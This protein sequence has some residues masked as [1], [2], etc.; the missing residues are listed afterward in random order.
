[1]ED[2]IPP[3]LDE[4]P[5]PPGEGFAALVPSITLG[6]ALVLL[7]AALI[8]FFIRRFRR[9]PPPPP[10][11]QFLAIAQ[12]ELNLLL[13]QIRSASPPSAY[14]VGTRV[15]STIRTYLG[16][17]L[18]VPLLPRTTQEIDRAASLASLADLPRSYLPLA[19]SCDDLTFGTLSLPPEDLAQLVSQALDA[20][21]PPRPP[22]PP[23]PDPAAVFAGDGNAI[24]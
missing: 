21:T 2:G 24:P 11:P 10:L 23:P 22:E 4:L 20:L 8:V 6:L 12:E 16:A 1:M 9:P 14:E 5:P 15:S 17:Q 13:A 7:L 18:A 3:F 19:R